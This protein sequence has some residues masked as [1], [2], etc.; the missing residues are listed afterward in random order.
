MI[1]IRSK[2]DGFR[3]CGMAHPARP[4]EYPD[5]KFSEEELEILKAEPMLVVEAVEDTGP[6]E[7]GP[8]SLTVAQLR[9][10][11]EGE[12]IP[13]NARKADLIELLKAKVGAGSD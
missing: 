5:D 7:D 9:E 13:P 8:E 12:E 6:K 11:L 1:R 4:V 2:Q 10:C 3:R